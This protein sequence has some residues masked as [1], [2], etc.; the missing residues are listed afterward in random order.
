MDKVERARELLKAEYAAHAFDICDDSDTSYL[1]E[2]DRCALRAIE[3]ALEPLAE[4]GREATGEVAARHEAVRMLSARGLFPSG[5]PVPWETV[6]DLL[7]AALREP[8]NV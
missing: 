6:L 1:A 3:A 5:G 2:R 7:S 4:R 8:S